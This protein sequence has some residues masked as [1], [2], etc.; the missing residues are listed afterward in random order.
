MLCIGVLSLLSC[1]QSESISSEN[2][3]L[4]VQEITDLVD[5]N[6]VSEEVEG[7]LEDVLVG[8]V[9]LSAKDATTKTT[10][11]D[12]RIKTVEDDGSTRT[13]TIDFGEG[14]E[15]RRGNVLSGK[16]IF[17]YTRDSEAQ[18][19]TITQSYENFY[20]N[21]NSI[22]G[23]STTVRLK[24]NE[25]E[26][27]QS[28]RSF[29]TKITKADGTEVSKEGVKV[30]EWIV[31]SD[32]EI[33]SDDVYLITGNWERVTKEGDLIEAAIVQAL[34]K[35]RSCKFIV[36]GVIEVEKNGELG[37]IDFGDGTCDDIA[38]FTNTNGDVEEIKLDKK[39]RKR[40]V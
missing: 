6:D 38:T 19:F 4:S 35:E 31:G 17:T 39:K 26:N 8:E 11:E 16:I 18:S 37:V 13:V 15:S 27:P 30:R 9:V 33:R 32:T 22:E 28:T 10:E 29:E 20:V 7:L 12:C 36:S 40:N 23:E 24:E 14:C 21:E 5:L 1:E 25:N 34:R 3:A 2:E